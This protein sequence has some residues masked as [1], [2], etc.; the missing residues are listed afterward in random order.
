M[1]QGTFSHSF[2]LTENFFQDGNLQKSSKISEENQHVHKLNLSSPKDSAEEAKIDALQKELCDL[3][4]RLSYMEKE[5]QILR[6]SHQKLTNAASLSLQCA[7]CK[8]KL[9]GGSDVIKTID[10]DSNQKSP[11]NNKRWFL[12]TDCVKDNIIIGSAKDALILNEVFYASP[13]FCNACLVEVGYCFKKN[14]TPT[15]VEN[16]ISDLFIFKGVDFVVK[17]QTAPWFQCFYPA[18]LTNVTYI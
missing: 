9:C 18:I 10:A 17:E 3:K 8:N 11:C 5:N 6:S 16:I 14:L 15:A 13:L 12:S 2:V 4:S 7:G 1:K